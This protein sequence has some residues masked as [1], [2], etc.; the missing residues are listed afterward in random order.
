MGLDTSKGWFS[1]PGIREPADRTLAEQ[2]IGLDEAL[3]R[4]RGKSVL[5]LGC[6]EGLISLEF[7]KAG[8]TSVVGIERHEFHLA[9]ARQVLA[10]SGLKNVTFVE[11]MLEDVIK[12]DE[13]GQIVW[14][15]DVVLALAIIH[16]LKDIA[17][18]LEFVARAAG[19]LIVFR[20]PHWYVPDREM[21]RPKGSLRETNIPSILKPRGFRKER[22]TVG[23]RGEL[24]EYWAK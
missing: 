12:A 5:D 14:H 11:R 7:A 13:D 24:V 15:A 19:E 6:A 18:G 22:R 10:R 3:D 1:V 9:V 8:A 2:M 20:W 4:A 17:S 16:K 21:L 23:P